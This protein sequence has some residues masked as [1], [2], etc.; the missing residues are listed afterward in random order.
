MSFNQFLVEVGMV[1]EDKPFE[2][3]AEQDIKTARQRYLNCLSVSV[4]GSGS[5]IIKRDPKDIFTNN[6]NPNLMLIHGANHD[7]QLVV[8][9][10]ACAHQK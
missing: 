10:Y 2:K 4:K 5:V 1:E 6:F 3:C 7:I 8:D 9:M